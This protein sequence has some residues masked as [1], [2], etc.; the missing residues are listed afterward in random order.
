VAVSE[1]S[2]GSRPRRYAT[3]WA[4]AAP[5]AA[6]A[7]LVLLWEVAV[8]ALH[9]PEFLLPP[10]SAVGQALV[11]APALLLYHSWITTYETVLG[12]AAAVAIGVPIAA[13]IV[14][15]PNSYRA[16]VPILVMIQAI[17]KVAVAP[18]LLIWLGAG[19]DS[20]VAMAVLIAFFPIIVD[21]ATGLTSANPDLIL[22]ARS[23]GASRWQT[24]LE[25]Q[26]PTAL[27]MMFSGLKVAIT[28]AVVGA[29]IAE[30]VGAEE[31]LGYLILHYSARRETAEVLA[32][33]I[34]LGVL[35]IVLFGIVS[36]LERVCVWWK[37][38]APEGALG[39][40]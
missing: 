22:M 16:L 27:P 20:K 35:G 3:A 7:V 13:L 12:F 40:A 32:C 39:V 8:R 30:F 1:A 38:A 28:L 31:G 34:L 10:P 29:V 19:L 21:T 6:L 24:L 17:P 4:V 9:V 11:G 36:A 26:F 2:A 23:L 15:S 37:P 33:I 25:I 5:V 18:I 14:L